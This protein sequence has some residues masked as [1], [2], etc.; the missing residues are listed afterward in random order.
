MQYK[1]V[2]ATVLFSLCVG[3]GKLIGRFWFVG[4]L[5]R[6]ANV[7]DSLGFAL[8]VFLFFTTVLVVIC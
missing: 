8:V 2:L 1:R 6:P 5:V 7:L 3:A 4:R